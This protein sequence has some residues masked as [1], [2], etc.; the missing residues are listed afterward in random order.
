VLEYER[1]LVAKVVCFTRETGL[2]WTGGS[3]G[4]DWTRLDWTWTGLDWT[5]LDWT[6]AHKSSPTNGHYDA[7][8]NL[9]Y[10]N[11]LCWITGDTS[12]FPTL[13]T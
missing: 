1:V 3:V 7:S 12:S 2:N 9:L 8:W 13:S 10:A 11:L 6:R 5:G 4:L